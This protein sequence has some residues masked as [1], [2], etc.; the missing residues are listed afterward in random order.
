MTMRARSMK[1]GLSDFSILFQ[2][3]FCMSDCTATLL[4]TDCDCLSRFTFLMYPNHQCVAHPSNR[5]FYF[6]KI[7]HSKVIVFLNSTSSGEHFDIKIEIVPTPD[8]EIPKS[9]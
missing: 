8:S 4:I 3:G 1:N 6:R 7:R 2:F 9:V 5:C